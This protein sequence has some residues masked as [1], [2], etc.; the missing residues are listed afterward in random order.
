MCRRVLCVDDWSEVTLSMWGLGS[1]VIELFSRCEA[2]LAL[3]CH[4]LSYALG[5]C[6]LGT[7]LKKSNARM[8]YESTQNST[9]ARGIDPWV[10]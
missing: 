5:Q 4:P 3:F 10:S 1:Q 7:T 6:R 8:I 2:I 9:M